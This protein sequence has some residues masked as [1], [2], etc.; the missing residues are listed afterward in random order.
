MKSIPGILGSEGA[1]QVTR[2]FRF[3]NFLLFALISMKVQVPTP[4][5]RTNLKIRGIQL[6]KSKMGCPDSPNNIFVSHS[7]DKSHITSQ[8]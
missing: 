5:P 6:I 8:R 7:D 1:S 2:S 3:P 4:T